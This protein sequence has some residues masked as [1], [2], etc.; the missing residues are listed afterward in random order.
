MTEMVWLIISV[1]KVYKITKFGLESEKMS[2]E[3]KQKAINIRIDPETH[4]QLRHQALD[5]GRTFKVFIQSVLT[6][7]A[8]KEKQQ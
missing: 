1:T 4:K 6:N 5:S 8:Q 2:D 3:A 7:Q